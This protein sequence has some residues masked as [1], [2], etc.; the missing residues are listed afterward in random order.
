VEACLIQDLPSLF[1]PASVIGFDDSTVLALA[2]EGEESATERGLT[3]DKLKV[4]EVGLRALKD[5]QQYSSSS[6][7][8]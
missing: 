7:G 5:V 2:S 1:S 3:Q 6:R 8:T 4:L